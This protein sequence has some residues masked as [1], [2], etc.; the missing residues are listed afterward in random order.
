MNVGMVIGVF[1]GAGAG[2]LISKAAEGGAI[3]TIIGVVVGAGLGAV[4]GQLVGEGIATAAA[5]Q[6]GPPPPPQ[7]PP[8]G[9]QKR[10][11]LSNIANQ[12]AAGDMGVLTV[13]GRRPY[14]QAGPWVA[15]YKTEFVP[16]GNLGN[17]A[18]TMIATSDPSVVEPLT[19]TFQS[20]SLTAVGPGTAEL[21]I[22]WRDENLT[23]QQSTVTV[24]AIESGSGPNV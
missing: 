6:V 8:P 12:M 24:N 17:A 16:A 10:P 11:V 2:A 13:T 7:V 18:I 4:G 9:G 14:G 1:A 23:A 21:T 3:G 20:V 5:S 15:D 22:G 19:G